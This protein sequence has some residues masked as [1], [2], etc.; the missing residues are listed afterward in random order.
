MVYPG[1]LNNYSFLFFPFSYDYDEE[2]VSVEG[3]KGGRLA[4]CRNKGEGAVVERWRR[5][6]EVPWNKEQKWAI[7]RSLEIKRWR[8]EGGETER[9]DRRSRRRR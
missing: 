2:W 7:S 8:T 9:K 4:E 5:P 6:K 3:M 1:V